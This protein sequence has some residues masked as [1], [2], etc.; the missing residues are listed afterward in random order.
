MGRPTGANYTCMYGVQVYT[1]TIASLDPYRTMMWLVAGAGSYS[2]ST[3]TSD[4][5]YTE[6]RAQNA[7][8]GSYPY[9][10]RIH[11][12]GHASLLNVSYPTKVDR[13][14]EVS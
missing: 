13:L 11:F 10:S 3:R 12:P 6:R 8:K 4:L 1:S 14:L 2:Y 9:K 7:G 5:K